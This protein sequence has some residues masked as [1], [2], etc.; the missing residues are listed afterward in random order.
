MASYSCLISSSTALSTLPC[1]AGIMYCGVRWNTVRWSAWRAMTGIDC[2]PLDPV[3]ITAT[4]LPAKSTP[5]W[6]QAP[7]W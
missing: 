6:G 1:R 5:S 3:P 7:V 4:F 2:T